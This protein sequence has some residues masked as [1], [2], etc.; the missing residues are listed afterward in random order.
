[1]AGW[2]WMTGTMACE[3]CGATDPPVIRQSWASGGG[4]RVGYGFAC[5][6]CNRAAVTIG[7]MRGVRAAHERRHGRIATDDPR[8]AAHQRA[9]AEH[10]A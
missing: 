3:C 9:R 6:A 5:S 4:V 8:I 7:L 10:I 1:M 2:A